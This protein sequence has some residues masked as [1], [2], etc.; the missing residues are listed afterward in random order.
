MARILVTGASGY[1]GSYLAAYFAAAGHEVTASARAL[2]KELSSA[3]P[4]C[5]LIELDVLR[6]ARALAGSWDCIIHTATA[7]DI[8]S[9]DFRAGLELSA[10]GTQEMLEAAVRLHVPHLIFFSTLQVLGA[11]LRGTFSEGSPVDLVNAYGFNHHAGELTCQLFSRVKGVATSIVRPANV[12]GCPLSRT[13][14][15]WTLVPLCFVREAMATGSLTIR[16]S[17][18]QKRDFISLRQIAGACNSLIECPPKT[19][20]TFNIATGKTWRVIDAA[21]WVAE[22]YERTVGH[23][24]DLRILGD[25][26]AVSND[27]VV[28]SSITPPPLGGSSAHEMKLEIEKIFEYF[29]TAEK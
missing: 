16:S 25:A 2:S 24:L 28:A 14:N 7:N 3:L 29:R 10:I 11:E 27:F 12:Y 17:G 9:R 23:S 15:R 13:V 6:S 19:T 21:H 20:S 18:L 4:L 8:I 5:N 26:P 22:I 1:I